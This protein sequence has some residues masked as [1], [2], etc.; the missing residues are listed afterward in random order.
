MNKRNKKWSPLVVLFFPFSLLGLLACALLVI[1][2]PFLIPYMM[3]EYGRVLSWREYFSW[4]EA[5][6]GSLGE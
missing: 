5:E 6:Q 2:Y 1:A 4:E 3:Y